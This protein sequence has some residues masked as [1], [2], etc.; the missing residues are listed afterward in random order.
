MI[1]GMGARI[2]DEESWL[3]SLGD[4][5]RVMELLDQVRLWTILGSNQ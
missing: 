2:N 4:S 3:P 1:E 5:I